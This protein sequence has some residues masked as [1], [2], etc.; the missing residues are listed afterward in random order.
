MKVYKTFTSF[1][2]SNEGDLLISS[3]SIE[4]LSSQ[5]KLLLWG[6]NQKLSPNIVQRFIF[7][8][9]YFPKLIIVNLH[10]LKLRMERFRAKPEQSQIVRFPSERHTNHWIRDKFRKKAVVIDRNLAI[11]CMSVKEQH[12]TPRAKKDAALNFKNYRNTE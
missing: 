3:N 8:L 11:F 12:R 5:N 6:L 1:W 4:K 7:N 2:N 9:S 10:L